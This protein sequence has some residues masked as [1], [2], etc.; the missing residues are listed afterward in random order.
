MTIKEE[1]YT[2]DVVCTN[3]GHKTSILIPKGEEFCSEDY[4][5]LYCGCAETLV[6]M[7]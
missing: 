4:K 3:C 6:R 1:K 2:L 7:L 5:C